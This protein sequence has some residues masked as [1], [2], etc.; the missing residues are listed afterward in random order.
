MNKLSYGSLGKNIWHP[1]VINKKVYLA[2]ISIIKIFMGQEIWIFMDN[3][4]SH[5][6]LR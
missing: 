1:R 5:Y 4:W 3:A 2:I 6:D